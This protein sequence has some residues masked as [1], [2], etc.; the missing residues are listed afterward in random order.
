MS[1]VRTIVPR[2]SGASRPRTAR[3]LS[4][5]LLALASASA[6]DPE[7][8]EDEPSLPVTTASESP[9][10]DELVAADVASEVKPPLAVLDLGDEV[11]LEFID[12]GQGGVMFAVG[13]PEAAVTK[14][15]V[16]VGE[17]TRRAASPE[18]L[19][20]ALAPRGVEPSA[21]LRERSEA[22]A[23]SGRWKPAKG[24]VKVAGGVDDLTAPTRPAASA[25]NAIWANS[26][27]NL[28]H[29]DGQGSEYARNLGATTNW[30]R[31]DLV[32]FGAHVWVKTGSVDWVIQKQNCNFCNVYTIFTKSLT[33]GSTWYTWDANQNDDHN[34]F[35][36]VT[37]KTNGGVHAHEV[38]SCNDWGTRVLSDGPEGGCWIYWQPGDEN[39]QGLYCTD[40]PYE[41]ADPSLIHTSL[42]WKGDGSLYF[43]G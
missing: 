40:L 22:V 6:C 39:A 38:A 17:A 25:P 42:G 4:S 34:I 43:C 10:V 28:A 37:S 12:S 7:L 20:R 33:Q 18:E 1:I 8:A 21:A 24:A 15:L 30:N 26:A 23:K 9:A 27:G 3:Y 36:E 11:S 41:G 13:G 31:T 16:E 29:N 19:F 32:G 2:M 35:S 5:L 14:K